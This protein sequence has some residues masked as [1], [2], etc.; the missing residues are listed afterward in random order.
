M[1]TN[2]TTRLFP[3]KFLFAKVLFETSF[4]HRNI[5]ILLTKHCK[6]L[7]LFYFLSSSFVFSAHEKTMSHKSKKSGSLDCARTYY[8]KLRCLNQFYFELEANLVRQKAFDSLRRKLIE[9]LYNQNITENEFSR[10]LRRIC[11]NIDYCKYS[12]L[13]QKLL[14]QSR[15]QSTKHRF[16]GRE[17]DVQN[18]K[19]NEQNAFHQASTATF[20]SRRKRMVR[21]D[22]RL[23]YLYCRTKYILEI[24]SNGVVMGNRR[25]TS[26]GKCCGFDKCNLF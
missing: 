20:K 25:K 21:G 17:T 3:I 5:A 1:F 23:I 15:Y 16:V 7:F 18:A 22:R 4:R 10:I 14:K 9:P 24:K 12:S 8:C 13:S 19:T 2:S 6:A 11:K 26:K